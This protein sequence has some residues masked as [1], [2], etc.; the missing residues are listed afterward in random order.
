[1]QK[2]GNLHS[3]PLFEKW[4]YC[5]GFSVA[6]PTKDKRCK[7]IQVCQEMISNL[8][9]PQTWHCGHPTGSPISALPNPKL[10]TQSGEVLTYSFSSSLDATQ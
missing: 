6:W 4:K 5:P 1:M 9:V 8:P 10:S 3:F 2:G 7:G